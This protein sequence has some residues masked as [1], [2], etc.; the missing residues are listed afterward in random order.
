MEDQ[1]ISFQTAEIAKEKGFDED[2]LYYYEKRHQIFP[3]YFGRKIDHSFLYPAPTQSLLQKW[4]RE[5]HKINV[6]VDMPYSGSLYQYVIKWYDKVYMEQR[7]HGNREYEDAL[8]D[9]LFE[10]LNIIKKIK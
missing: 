6:Y 3:T 9:G 4:L 8:E 2:A 10:A 7:G 1:L 5:K